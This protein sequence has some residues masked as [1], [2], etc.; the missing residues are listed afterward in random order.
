MMIALASAGTATPRSMAMVSLAC[1]PAGSISVM[2]PTLTPATRT[3]S[4]G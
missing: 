1:P 3:S 4:P 2:V